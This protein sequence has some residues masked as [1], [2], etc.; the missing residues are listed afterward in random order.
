MLNVKLDP[1]NP[2][3]RACCFE[4][5]HLAGV[6]GPELKGP[7]LSVGDMLTV[8][9]HLPGG[10]TLESCESL[11]ELSIVDRRAGVIALVDAGLVWGEPAA[12]S[13][14]VQNH[15]VR[16]VSL[17]RAGKDQSIVA[18]WIWDPAAKSK[19]TRLDADALVAGWLQPGGLLI[20]QSLAKKT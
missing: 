19:E 2:S 17:E 4:L 10:V 18:A 3:S 20:V 16:V 9:G 15:A 8:L 6:P 1:P 7:A 5:A 11:E 14:S 13:G 12:H